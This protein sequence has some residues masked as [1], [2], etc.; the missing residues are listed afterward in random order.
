M[1]LMEIEI[2]S[3]FYRHGVFWLYMENKGLHITYVALNLMDGHGQPDD[4]LYIVP[5]TRYLFD[6]GT[7]AR[8][9]QTSVDKRTGEAMPER[10]SAALLSINETRKQSNFVT[11]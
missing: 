3:E 5:F 1:H 7:H 11:D 9:Y 2:D 6:F 10:P 4:L 8:G